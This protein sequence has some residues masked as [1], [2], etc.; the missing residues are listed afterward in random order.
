[1]F[2]VFL[3]LPLIFIAWYLARNPLP[4]RVSSDRK[5]TVTL[6]PVEFN[7]GV[8][9]SQTEPIKVVVPFI[10]VSHT[11]TKSHQQQPDSKLTSSKV[12]RIA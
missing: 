8:V 1:M 4:D 10:N 5:I 7:C 2:E 3:G 9:M 12:I 6:L 11:L